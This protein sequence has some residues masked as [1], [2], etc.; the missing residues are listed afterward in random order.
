MRSTVRKA[1]KFAVNVANIKTTNSQYA[2]TKALP[3]SAF[4]ASP[5]P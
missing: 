4:G 1:A 3:E 2:A 5:P